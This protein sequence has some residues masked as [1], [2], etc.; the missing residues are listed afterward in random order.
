MVRV[1]S[2]EQEPLW[3]GAIVAQSCI[4]DGVAQELLWRVWMGWVLMKTL[5]WGT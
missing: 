3:R 5:V 1:G 4:L 2:L